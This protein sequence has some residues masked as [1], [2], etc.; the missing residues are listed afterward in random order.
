MWTTQTQFGGEVGGN[1]FTNDQSLGYFEGSSYAPRFQD[2]IIIDGY[3]YYTVVASFTGAPIMGGSGTGPTV[4]VNLKTGQQLWSNEN[5][6]QLSFGITRT[7]ST[8]L[9]NTEFSRQYLSQT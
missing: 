9:T 1:L 5:I 3:L 8:I 6:P 7:T 2:P 4:C